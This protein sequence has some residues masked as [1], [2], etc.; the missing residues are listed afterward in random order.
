[1]N[2]AMAIDHCMHVYA[3]ECGDERGGGWRVLRVG[4]QIFRVCLYASRV[5]VCV[6][7]CVCCA[8]LGRA[9]SGTGSRLGAMAWASSAAVDARVQAAP[10]ASAFRSALEGGKGRGAFRDER[11]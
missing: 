8:A 3:C 7:V 11:A 10:S 5:C 2:T 9:P 6:C 4:I 1:M